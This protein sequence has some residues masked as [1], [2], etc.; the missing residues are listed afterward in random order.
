MR[1]RLSRFT[2]STSMCA[3]GGA[4]RLF[5]AFIECGGWR[6][7]KRPPPLLQPWPQL[8]GKDEG[9]T[10]PGCVSKGGGVHPGRAS[11]QP[12]VAFSRGRP[13]RLGPEPWSK[14]LVALRGHRASLAR[15]V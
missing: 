15:H 5:S 13:S 4:P 10:R 8:G 1:A 3:G 7:K 2:A 9:E 11:R 6:R 14:G 12:C